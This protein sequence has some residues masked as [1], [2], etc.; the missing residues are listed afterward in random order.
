MKLM[1]RAIAVATGDGHRPAERAK[2]VQA[3]LRTR[4]WHSD[5]GLLTLD[6]SGDPSTGAYGVY[7]VSGGQLSYWLQIG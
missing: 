3:L 4:G 2:V 1:L 6:A 7:K 5:L